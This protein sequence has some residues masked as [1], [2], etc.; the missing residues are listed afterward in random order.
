MNNLFTQHIEPT[1]EQLAIINAL[2]NEYLIKVNAFAGTGKTS[3]LQ[4]LTNFYPGK[5]FLYLAYNKSMQED[6]QK[7]FNINVDVKTVHAF[8]YNYIAK[9]TKLNLKEIFLYIFGFKDR[10]FLRKKVFF[11][12]C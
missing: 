4:M 11:N 5:K 3:M 7:K 2:P 9:H 1:E 10:I 6:A 12:Y 8:A